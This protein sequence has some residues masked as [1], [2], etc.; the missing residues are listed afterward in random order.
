MQRLVTAAS[1]YIRNIFTLYTPGDM[2]TLSTIGSFTLIRGG[3][4]PAPIPFLRIDPIAAGTVPTTTR[5]G[6]YALTVSG[7]VTSVVDDATRGAVYNFATGETSTRASIPTI[8]S[9]VMSVCLWVYN[10]GNHVSCVVCD[11]IQWVPMYYNA[12]KLMSVTVYHTGVGS[13]VIT[14]SDAAEVNTWHHY[15]VTIGNTNSTLYRNGIVTGTTQATPSGFK[16]GV[17]NSN[18]KYACLG[19]SFYGNANAPT[20]A[21]G[22]FSGR[23]HDYRIYI[24][25]ELT[26][27]QIQQIM[28]EN[29]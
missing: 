7:T 21:K 26:A 23:L 20:G 16:S 22:V 2:N 9:N 28:L 13:I 5:V 11:T 6:G 15:T 10:T 18:G 3:P 27:A 29:D 17:I 8:P 12:S 25:L 24:P 19:A 14:E 4:P 1:L